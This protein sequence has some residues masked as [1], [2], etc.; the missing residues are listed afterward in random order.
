VNKF[1]IARTGMGSGIK[2]NENLLR[3]QTLQAGVE[4]II[5]ELLC[6]KQPIMPTFPSN[7]Q[8]LKETGLSIIQY[9]YKYIKLNVFNCEC[10]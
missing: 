4:Y 6:L 9:N 2:D 1:P 7:H 5:T 10:I 3:W 8:V